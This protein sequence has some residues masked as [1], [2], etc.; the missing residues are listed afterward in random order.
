MV[1]TLVE[2]I[3]GQANAVQV[4]VAVGLVMSD[5]T[6]LGL[7]DRPGQLIGYGPVP[8]G[9]ARWLAAHD[10]TWARR[11][12]TDP[13][14]GSVA[15][16]DTRRRRFDGALRELIVSRDQH[17]RRPGCRSRFR[18]LDHTVDWTD[19]GETTAANGRG[20]CRRCH[21]AKSRRDVTIDAVGPPSSERI[22][23]AAYTRWK[24]PTGGVLSTIPPLEVSVSLQETD[25]TL[26]PT[27]TESS[28][29]DRAPRE[30]FT[31][32]S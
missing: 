2:R 15:L 14:D 3:T 31:L 10:S 13:V 11:L 22:G 28:V 4:P 5:L 23:A 20:Y 25:S 19:G 16:A 18:D 21:L 30:S 7:E 27:D 8:S 12:Y 32:A 24:M 17:C 26:I 29:L 1:D 6:L 9:V